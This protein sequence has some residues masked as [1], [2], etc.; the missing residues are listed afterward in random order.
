M[1]FNI[2]SASESAQI[3][4]SVA[5][6]GTPR[7]CA[8][9]CERFQYSPSLRLSPCTLTNPHSWIKLP[10][11]GHTTDPAPRSADCA[12]VLG[13]SWAFAS[14]QRVPSIFLSSGGTASRPE[15]PERGRDLNARATVAL[16]K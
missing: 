1:E 9:S 8:A 14:G 13:F 7:S 3:S 5:N 10:G 15:K 6:K 11:E 16:S 12:R 2:S 4:V